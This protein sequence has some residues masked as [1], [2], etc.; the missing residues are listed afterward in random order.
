VATA[1]VVVPVWVHISDRREDARLRLIKERKDT[2]LSISELTF[3][4]HLGPEDKAKE[5]VYK[6]VGPIAFGQVN[7]VREE[8]RKQMAKEVQD[9]NQG[10]K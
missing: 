7:L 9:M 10:K 6:V 8:L 2:Y 1:R 3:L 5:L 4:V